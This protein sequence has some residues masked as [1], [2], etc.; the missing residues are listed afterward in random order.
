MSNNKREFLWLTA[1]LCLTRIGDIAMTYLVTPDLARETNP[2][3]S[4]FGQGWIS[5]IAVQIVLVLAIVLLNYYGLFKVKP[6]Y[7]SQTGLSFGEFATTYYL[8]RKQHWTNLLL[9][10]PTRWSVFVKAFG[11]A[12]PRALI[13]IGLLVSVSSATLT[14]SKAYSDFYPAVRPVFYVTLVATALYFYFR[15][16]KVEYRAYCDSAGLAESG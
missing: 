10:F 16:F 1:L 13:V 8:G 15:F 9:R 3:V 12:L 11:Y 4:L 14:V 7:P 2:L 6:A 5:V